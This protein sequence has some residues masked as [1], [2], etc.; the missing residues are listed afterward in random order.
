[1]ARV[2]KQRR[3]AAGE[4]VRTSSPSQRYR[5]DPKA[6]AQQRAEGI[7]TELQTR[8]ERRKG[9]LLVRWFS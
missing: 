6:S 2:K 4:C 9:V 5:R 3:R 7:M 8:Q 1:M